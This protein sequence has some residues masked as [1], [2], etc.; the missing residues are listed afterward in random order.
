MRR[1]VST[2][3]TVSATNNQFT[4]AVVD[5]STTVNN[6]LR[7]TGASG[8]TLSGNRVHA[9]AT[10]AGASLGVPSVAPGTIAGYI[11]LDLFGGT[12]Q[13]PVGDETIAN[14]NV[15]AFSY[16]G[17]VCNA[18]RGGLQRL[19]RRRRGHLGGQQLLSPA[20]R[21]DPRRGRTTCSRRSGPTWT[22]PERPAS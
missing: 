10:L 6:P 3:C 18:D 2:V 19:P 4:D 15:P 8:A 22:A 20:D 11:P 17:A 1:N 13:T 7:L 21:G 14:F 5:L 12:L 16:N 9:T